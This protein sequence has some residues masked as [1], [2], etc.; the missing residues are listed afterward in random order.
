MKKLAVTT[1]FL[2]RM[3]GCCFNQFSLCKGEENYSRSESQGDDT[4]NLEIDDPST[5]ATTGTPSIRRGSVS[6]NNI[7][8]SGNDDNSQKSSPSQT[9]KRRRSERGCV[10][11]YLPVVGGANGGGE[12]DPKGLSSRS[13][14]QLISDSKAASGPPRPSLRPGEMAILQKKGTSLE[15]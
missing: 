3:L 10:N 13:W 4:F 8:V 6:T 11:F 12:E 2:N 15:E 1:T 9:D 7:S 5:A 14:P